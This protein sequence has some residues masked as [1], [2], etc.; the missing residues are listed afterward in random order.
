MIWRRPPRQPESAE[1]RRAIVAMGDTHAGHKLGLCHPGVA[2]VRVNDDGGV[3]LFTPELTDTQRY[4]WG[5]YQGHQEQVLEF[6]GGPADLLIHGGDS[7]HGFKHNGGLMDVDAGEQVAIARANL[8]P[9]LDSAKRIRF[10]SGTAAHVAMGHATASALIAAQLGHE[11][12]SA[13]HHLRIEVGGVLFDVAHHGP[14]P[15]S[16]EW[17]RGNVARY[18]LRS[19]VLK[20]VNKLG[21]APATVY[22]RFHHHIWLHEMLEMEVNG[23]SHWAHLVVCPSYCGLNDYARQV[24]QSTPE[25]TNGLVVFLVED[26]RLLEV[27]P[28]KAT[29]DLRVRETID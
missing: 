6:I 14:G 28:F 27:R 17:L 23:G 13:A 24:T 3:Q 21:K 16:R 1:K 18:Y 10:V 11:D 29:R 26:G 2:L 9:W 5:L 20:D 25:L 4:L 12:A 22:L 19:R 15:G 7:T 8:V